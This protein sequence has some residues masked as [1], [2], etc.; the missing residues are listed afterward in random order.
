MHWIYILKCSNEIK[1]IGTTKRLY[2]RFWQHQGGNGGVNTTTYPPECLVA[3]Y[4]VGTLSNFFEYNFNV[5]N[6]ICNI[7]FNRCG[8]LLEDFNDTCDEDGDDYE[9]DS[10]SAETN[11][12]EC[13][14]VNDKDNWEKI[15][16]AKYTRFDCTYKFPQNENIKQLP[17]CNCG[18]PCDIKKN[19]KD[20]YLFFRCA[21]KNMYWLD[22]EDFELELEDDACNYFMKYTADIEYKK[23]YANKEK[24]IKDLVSKSYWLKQ[25]VGGH[26]EHC[27]GGCGKEFDSE[28]T[29]RY[30]RTAINL[31]FNCF[32]DKNAVLAKKY[33]I[34]NFIKGKCLI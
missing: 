2:T 5:M 25:L 3:I 22:A 6:K 34:Y 31:C 20:N 18:L 21:K 26:Y 1:Y 11:I 13:L 17:M 12:A 32:V 28:N 27:V 19:E 4:K 15:R 10:L 9:Y 7:Y 30:S 33:N 8:R 24:K 29:I 14:M 23:F 16:G